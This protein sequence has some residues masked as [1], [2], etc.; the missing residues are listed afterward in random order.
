MVIIN[1]NRKKMPCYCLSVFP[2]L[3]IQEYHYRPLDLLVVFPRVKPFLMLMGAIQG[4]LKKD[5]AIIIES[6]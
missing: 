6:S 4:S 2:F 1:L 3:V 5:T